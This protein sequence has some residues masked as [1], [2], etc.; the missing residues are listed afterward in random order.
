MHKRLLVTGY[1]GFVAG[2]VVKQA[3][4]DWEVFALSR[5]AVTGGRADITHIQLDIR[6]RDRLRAAFEYARP[7]AIIHC[8]A[9]AD[10][11]RC[12][13]NQQEAESVNVGVTAHLA[14]LCREFSTRMVFCS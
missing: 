13:S 5:S 7:S 1:G 3:G 11:D 12:Q 14:E 8:A 4:A 6:D 2:S 10:I 9:M